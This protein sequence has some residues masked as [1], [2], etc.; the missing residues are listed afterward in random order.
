MRVQVAI[1][2]GVDV[3]QLPNDFL[4]RRVSHQ[5]SRPALRLTR[6]FV[7]GVISF[8]TGEYVNCSWQVTG[9]VLA[10]AFVAHE[11]IPQRVDSNRLTSCFQTIDG[12][13][14]ARP[15]LGQV[16]QA[17]LAHRQVIAATTTERGL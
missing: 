17:K 2:F 4:W 1:V 9:V 15:S 10:E 6:V 5:T 3:L 12:F 8:D 13:F 16:P 14:K 11:G 7:L